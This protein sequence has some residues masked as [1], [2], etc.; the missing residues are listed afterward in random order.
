[1]YVR[2][3]VLG[4]GRGNI[5]TYGYELFEDGIRFSKSYGVLGL[6]MT[7]FHNS[8][9]TIL[10]C[11][12]VIGFILFFIFGLRFFTRITKYVFRDDSLQQSVLPCMYAFLCAYVVYS[13]IEIALV[14]NPSLIV[15]MFWLIL[16]YTSC[17]LAKYEPDE[18]FGTFTVFGRKL[19][20]TL[21]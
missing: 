8:Y 17:F 16:G 20:K 12:G 10:V 15:M 9:L 14:F 7:D 4:I 19:P 2:H 21:L 11:S 6:F 18:E 5:N 13:F 1:M 3:P